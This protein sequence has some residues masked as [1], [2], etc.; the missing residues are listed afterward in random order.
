MPLR[1]A[2]AAGGRPG[3]AALLA[4]ALLAAP[5][6]G[7][8][9][10]LR[11]VVH[12]DLRNTDPIWTTA[13]IT[14]NHGYMVYDTLFA[15][16]EAFEV[17]PQ[18][19]D[20][21]S[22][23]ED[24]LVWTFTLRDGLRWHDGAPVTAADCAASIRR[25]GARDGMGQKLMDATES[26]EAV[27]ERTLRLVLSRPYGLVLESLGKASS[28]VPFMMPLR[29]AE[30]DPF[31]QV[32]EV[33]GSGPYR[34]AAE[35]WVPGARVVY[36]RNEDYV[37]RDEP[38]SWAAGGKVA[39]VD[40]VEWLYIPDPA[41]AMNALLSG[42]VDYFELPPHDLL[43]LL[44]ASPDVEV[45]NVDP[46]GV[47]GHLRLNHLHP[48]FDHP[49]ARE[50]VLWLVDQARFLASVVGDPRHWRTCPAFFGC[51]GPYESGSGAEALLARDLDRAR[52]LFAEAGYDGRP[53]VVMQPTDIAILSGVALVAAGMLREAGLEVDL[54]AMDWSTLTSRRALDAPPG[55]GG[56]NVFP[57]W[58]IG[59]D[60]VDPVVHIGVSGGCRERAWFGW[61]CD[62]ELEGLRDAFAYEGDPARRAELAERVQ[63]RA[64]EVVPYVNY[65]Q[66]F[67]P[68]AYRANLAGVL[69]S[70][71]NL[72]WNIEKR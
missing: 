59:M 39:R 58:F 40:T 45:V 51:G 55:E 7:A 69:P 3:A 47:Q 71:V 49:K 9:T 52:A 70:P 41:T 37:P 29:H 14:R 22:V 72:F 36:R 42:E 18:M 23:S 56:W 54:Q 8:E 12:A 35:E 20:S 48:P 50:A 17:R 32:P 64:Y 21:W 4:A 38:P 13:Y 2:R 30:T 1:P 6:A 67:N 34:F 28:N 24:G 57:T 33:V 26:L 66:W 44:E 5:P 15:I 60:I 43:P 10:T 11:A 53:V 46:V 61:P 65:G 16:D 27:D 19:V 25:W 31:E 63:R 68:I 62:A